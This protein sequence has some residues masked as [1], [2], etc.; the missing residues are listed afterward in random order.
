M[1]TSCWLVYLCMQSLWNSTL[2]SIYMELWLQFQNANVKKK[3]ISRQLNFSVHHSHTDASPRCC[4]LLLINDHVFSEGEILTNERFQLGK[5]IKSKNSKYISILN[6]FVKDIEKFYELNQQLSMDDLA[7]SISFAM[8][9]GQWTIQ[10]LPFSEEDQHTQGS[11]WWEWWAE[12]S[13][14]WSDPKR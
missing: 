12:W 10:I 8:K 6:N 2:I 11:V 5:V 13:E 14:I 1:S 9:S 4:I 7:R 3:K